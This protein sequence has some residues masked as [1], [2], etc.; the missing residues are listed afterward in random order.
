[1]PSTRKGAAHSV[2][3][4]EM[5]AIVHNVEAESVR[6]AEDTACLPSTAGN[7]T[8]IEWNRRAGCAIVRR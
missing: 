2:D 8:R 3:N 1:M 7:E 6:L 4:V 5:H